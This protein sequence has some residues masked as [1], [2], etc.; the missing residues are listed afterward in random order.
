MHNTYDVESLLAEQDK[1][2]NNDSSNTRAALITESF[3]LCWEQLYKVS[4][5]R[6]PSRDLKG[7]AETH[8]TWVKFPEEMH[9]DCHILKVGIL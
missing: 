9:A 8:Q 6:S 1:D 5:G 3:V 4:I 2:S 7:F